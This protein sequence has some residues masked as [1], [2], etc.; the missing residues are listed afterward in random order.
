MCISEIFFFFFSLRII[1]RGE[2]AQI[3]CVLLLFVFVFLF[4]RYLLLLFFLLEVVWLADS[5]KFFKGW[6]GVFAK[7]AL[8]TLNQNL[9][10]KKLCGNS[11]HSQNEDMKEEKKNRLNI[12]LWA[13]LSQKLYHFRA[14]SICSRFGYTS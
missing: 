1:F 11:H 13:T 14:Q 3:D 12:C 4:A 10:G 2:I 9:L 6:R 7:V 5:F 8:A